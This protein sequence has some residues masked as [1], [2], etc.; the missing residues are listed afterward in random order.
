MQWCG[1]CGVFIPIAFPNELE[2]LLP[3]FIAVKKPIMRK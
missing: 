1:V 2:R 3:F